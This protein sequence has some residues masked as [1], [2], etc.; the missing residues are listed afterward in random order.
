MK[1]TVFNNRNYTH[2]LD[3]PPQNAAEETIK[4][5]I[6]SIHT[7][8]ITDYL[9]GQPNNKVLNQPAP[10]I[11]KSEEALDRSTRRTLAQ[12][13]TNK[14][15][16]LVSYLHKIDPGTHPT[17]SCPL[18]GHVNHDTTHLFQCPA[19]PTQLIPDDLWRDPVAAGGLVAEWRGALG[20]PP[21]DA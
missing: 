16:L 9:Q 7:H 20:R 18:C 13:R 2:N 12:L 19:I 11:H 10:S 6:K 3:I 17:P 5:N 15:P 1:Q 14:S 4:E 8:H 21:E